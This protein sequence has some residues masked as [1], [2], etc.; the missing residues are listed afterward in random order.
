VERGG[1]IVLEIETVGEVEEGCPGAEIF[2]GR[3][4]ELGGDEEEDDSGD[5]DG[6]V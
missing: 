5:E 3:K 1:E 4:G 6:G 2:G